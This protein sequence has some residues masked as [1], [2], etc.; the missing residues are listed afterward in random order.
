MNREELEEKINLMLF[1]NTDKFGDFMYSYATKDLANL[2]EAYSDEQ[3]DLVGELHL[4]PT[5][6]L[7]P[8]ED[9]WRKE[10][11]PCGK[12]VI[13]DTTKFYEWIVSKIMIPDMMFGC[14]DGDTIFEDDFR[15]VIKDG[16]YWR[17]ESKLK[18]T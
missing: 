17:F 13:P 10:N 16:N 6:K 15:K 8:L 2:V 14:S 9:L 5:E 3:C 11:Y 4:K 18:N 7:K 12:F 1:D